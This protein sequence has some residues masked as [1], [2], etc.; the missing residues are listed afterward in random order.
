MSFDQLVVVEELGLPLR[1]GATQSLKKGPITLSCCSDGVLS[2]R[3]L[4]KRVDCDKNGNDDGLELVLLG[5][6]LQGAGQYA[7]PLP[8]G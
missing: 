6:R 8:L 4:L 3:P 2:E 1:E 7:W 5:V